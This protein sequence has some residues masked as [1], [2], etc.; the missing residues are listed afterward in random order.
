MQCPS[1]SFASSAQICISCDSNCL[2]CNLSPDICLTCQN[3][4]FLYNQRCFDNLPSGVYA[5]GNIC[6]MCNTNCTACISASV[7]TN[8]I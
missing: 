8:C 1:D 5:I 2:T 4:Y 6:Y 3:N 7:C